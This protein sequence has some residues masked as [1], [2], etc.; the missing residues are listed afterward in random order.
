MYNFKPYIIAEWFSIN[1]TSNVITNMTFANNLQTQ[2]G[3]FQF[4][5]L[6][7]SLRNSLSIN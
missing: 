6:V 4:P 5:L 7:K 2:R 3:H 1:F